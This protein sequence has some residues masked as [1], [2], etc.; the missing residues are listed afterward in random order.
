MTQKNEPTLALPRQFGKY[1]LVRKIA[2]GGMAEIYKAKTAGA[3][4][5]EKDVVIK[6]ILPHFTEDES[7]VKMFIDEA[8]ITSKLQHANIVQIFDFDVCEGSYYIAMELI[9]GVD[10]KKVIDVG[11]KSGKPLSIP[12]TVWI[13]MEISKGLH[14]AHTKEY[15]GQPLNIVHRDISPHNA[16][17]SYAGEVK[18]MDFGIAKA[19]QRSTKTMAGTVKG[20]VAYMSPEQARGKP[21][22]GRSDLFA[23]GIMLWEMLTGKRLFLGDSDFETLTNVLK[24][25]AP[26]PSQINPKIPK[27]L[28]EI[29]LKALKKDRD[30]RYAS[31]EAFARDLTRWYYSHVTDL[32]A[33]SLKRFMH[34]LF[35]EDIQKL[36]ALA[37]EEKGLPT[38][39]AAPV[40]ERTVAM[41]A[42]AAPTM[43]E[44]Q[45]SR[46][47]LNQSLQRPGTTPAAPA[48]STGSY[49]QGSSQMTGATGA[50]GA[51][52]AP[53]EKKSKAW[54]WILLVLLLGG[55]GAAA[56]ILLTGGD[57]SVKPAQVEKPVEAAP[58][59]VAELLLSVDPSSAK[60]TVDGKPAEEKV[61]DLEIGKKVKVVAEAPGYQRYEEYVSIEKG[62]TVHKFKLEKEREK[63]SIVIEADD[64]AATIK[65][66]GK[67]FATGAKM[68][69]GFKGDSIAIEVTSSKGGEPV[70]REVLLD[71]S[72]GA[73]IKIAVNAQD[74]KLRLKLETTGA[75]VKANKGSVAMTADGS[76]AEVSGLKVGDSVEVTIEKA[77]FE[78]KKENVLLN[79]PS[80]ELT[81]KLVK[82][83]TTPVKDPVK[84]PAKDPVK[85][86]AK[87]PVKD[88]V[89]DPTPAKG[90]G[91]VVINAR[92]WAQIQIDG[93]PSG[94]TPKT[95]Q[96]APG[97]H[98][99]T[100]MNGGRTVTKSV[101]VKAGGEHNV[102][103]NFQE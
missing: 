93:R 55:G 56:A 27:D 51:G 22:D 25:D 28:D 11:L 12:Q 52:A 90:N 40:N 73:V 86:P 41:D 20:K 85:D 2:M 74:S 53:P 38:P 34:E 32:E 82:K 69:E 87:D 99:I 43:M 58:K 37:D 24:N 68:Y 3:E 83:A 63:I 103:H 7:F 35:I 61:T 96:L 102:F 44:G 84:D 31:V 59:E 17:V 67:P 60:V 45:L 65:V 36:Q 81:I 13:M 49:Q 70:K 76:A 89:K 29:V 15:K 75:T 1:V 95:V 9:E 77:D 48:H 72:Q 4:G 71:G 46:D 62:G 66:D 5:F 23:L 10:L 100:L 14:Y 21:L 97:G 78:P 33:E 18:L 98:S 101:T 30:E 50:Y 91:T 16:M 26:P 8:S 54:L 42:S 80:V 92:P 39:A 6:R 88:P 79:G 57:E 47:Q 64:P 94:T 19:A